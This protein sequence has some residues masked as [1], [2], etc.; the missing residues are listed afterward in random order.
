MLTFPPISTRACRLSPEFQ[1]K[2]CV[3]IFE[4]SHCRSR[5]CNLSWPRKRQIPSILCAGFCCF[6]L[7]VCNVFSPLFG[8]KQYFSPSHVIFIDSRNVKV[9]IACKQGRTH[10][11]QSILTVNGYWL[12]WMLPCLFWR[13]I[14][15]CFEMFL[16]SPIGV[17]SAPSFR[18]QTHQHQ[19]NTCK[20]N[21]I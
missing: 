18:F 14:M 7:L 9:M 21:H 6:I 16:F 1:L 15:F 20:P 8:L 10:W 12:F 19:P 13:G 3:V 2:Y 17:V 5:Q 11:S 4:T